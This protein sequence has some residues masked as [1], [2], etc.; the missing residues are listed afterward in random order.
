MKTLFASLLIA[1][2]LSTSSASFAAATRTTDHGQSEAAAPIAV[3]FAQIEKSK[4]DVVFENALNSSMGIRLTDAGGKNIATKIL[5]KKETGTRVRFDLANLKDGTYS[6]RVCN[7]KNAQ[8]KKFEIKT[9][10][11]VATSYQEVTFI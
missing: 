5:P 9:E 3:T 10:I 1:L 4:L 6:V 2:T 7:G 8:V 11:P